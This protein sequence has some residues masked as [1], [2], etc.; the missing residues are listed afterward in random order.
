MNN[1]IKI[2]PNLYSG[3]LTVRLWDPLMIRA[4]GSKGLHFSS[5]ASCSTYSLSLRSHKASSTSQ[6]LLSL[7]VVPQYW[8]LQNAEVSATRVNFYQYSDLATQYQAFHEPSVLGVLLH[9]SLYLHQWPLIK[10]SSPAA[11]CQASVA[12]YAFKTRTTLETLH[13]TKFGCQH[14]L[15]PWLLMDNSFCVLTLWKYFQRFQ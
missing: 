5:S 12:L 11:Q 8:R 15:Q 10:D 4:L 14:K 1:Q 3:N 13:I 9:L 6:L 2:K 7:V